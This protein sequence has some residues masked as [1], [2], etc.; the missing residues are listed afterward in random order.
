MTTTTNLECNFTLSVRDIPNEIFE[1]VISYLNVEDRKIASLV[2]RQW[3]LFAFS[4]K[5]LADVLLEINCAQHS[6]KDYWVVLEKSSRNYRNLV[7]N[8]A[9][10]DDGCLLEILGKFQHSLKR[11]SI[12]QDQDAR[13]LHTEISSDYFVQM[14]ERFRNLKNFEVKTVF[15]ILD[16]EE[17]RLPTLPFL[18]TIC[19]YTHGLEKEWFNWFTIAPNI[20]CIGV[21]LEDG[22]SG[23]PKIINDCRQQILHLS[24]DARFVERDQLEFCNEKFPRL[25]KLRLLYPISLPASI[26]TIRNFI[27]NCSLLTEISL[28][29]NVIHSDTLETIANHCSQLQIV[30]FDANEISPTAFA[31]ISKLPK[32]CQLILHKMTVDSAM[33]TAAGCFSML[34]QFTCLSIRINV[35][36][37]FFEQLRKK[38]PKLVTLE[39]LDRFRFGINNFNQ[40]GVVQAICNNIHSLERLALVDWAI[41]DTSIFGSLHKL[42]LITDLRLKCIGLNADKT[43]PPCPTL[44]RLILDIDSLKPTD[45]IPPISRPPIADVICKSFP[46]I[47]TLELRKTFLDRTKISEQEVKSLRSLM[48]RCTVYRKTRLKMADKDYTALL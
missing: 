1:K 23:F 14:M 6:A 13:L 45:T 42:N 5:A 7:L 18:E 29:S 41:L 33:I 9:D 48:P 21:P 43:I 35:P 27:G 10:D 25:Q 2:C 3:S 15:E 11:V 40:T 36:D 30:N 12:E 26:E 17:K 37:A 31:I 4:R 20:K 39:L 22:K 19:F 44:K 28:F 24:I 8:F 16:N 32:L 34:H 38:M 47:T 46:N